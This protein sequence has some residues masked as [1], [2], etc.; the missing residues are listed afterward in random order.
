MRPDVSICAVTF[1]RPRGLARLLDSL[2]ALKLPDGVT[3]ETVIVDNDPQGSAYRE[4]ERA[5]TAGALSLHWHHEP[6]GDIAR[7]RNRCIDQSRGRWLALVDDDEVVHPHW[8]LAYWEIAA[9]C[10]AD[11]FFGP[12]L[13]RLEVERES[14]L[15][16]PTFY[17]RRRW[18]SGTELGLEGPCTANA[19]LRRELMQRVRFDPAFGRTLG[20]DT[21]CFLRARDGGA[22]FVWCDEAIVTEI[23]PPERHRPGWLCHRAL[24]GASAWEHV[25]ARRSPRPAAAALVAGLARLTAALAWLPVAA[26]AGRRSAFRACLRICTQAGRLWGVFGRSVHRRGD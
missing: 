9:R 25:L 8:L 3:A 2:A 13:P 18:P 1:R 10:E 22:R 14:W 12:V 6:R 26:L 20:E 19:F 5:G 23:V 16:L 15:D 24:E 4:P 11:G 17:A 21:D 7:A